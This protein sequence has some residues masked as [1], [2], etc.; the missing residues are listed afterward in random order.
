M[1][2]TQGFTAPFGE[3]FSWLN[4][5]EKLSQHPA[6][7]KSWRDWG[8][9]KSRWPKIYAGK[10][11]ILVYNDYGDSW[12]LS[13]DTIKEI[14]TQ[15]NRLLLYLAWVQNISE[16]QTG[17]GFCD[18]EIGKFPYGKQK[19]DSSVNQL[20]KRITLSKQSLLAPTESLI[21]SHFHP[22]QETL[23]SPSERQPSPVIQ[24]QSQAPL[25]T[26]VI[27][28]GS[29]TRHGPKWA[30]RECGAGD[31]CRIYTYIQFQGLKLGSP[32]PR[33][34]LRLKGTSV[35]PVVG[36]SYQYDAKSSQE[37]R[38][39][40]DWRSK[41]AFSPAVDRTQLH[42]SETISGGASSL[43]PCNVVWRPLPAAQQAAVCLHSHPFGTAE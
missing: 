20:K 22:H 17:A 8:I 1:P 42:S 3:R 43:S 39:S 11:D 30:G 28:L 14:F 19:R 25:K 16:R 9:Q 40:G 37:A 15:K 5:L 32:S 41:W 29:A 33:L 18:R 4:V 7:T 10:R 35:D 27:Q 21:C 6:S 13:V 31:F 26:A 38:W 23:D 12:N 2:A 34:Q 36:S 24:T